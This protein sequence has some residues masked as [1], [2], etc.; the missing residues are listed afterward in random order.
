VLRAIAL[1]LQ[2]EERFFDDK[3]DEKFVNMHAS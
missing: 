2:L 1:G 3:V